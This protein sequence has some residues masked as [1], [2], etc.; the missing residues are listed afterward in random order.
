MFLGGALSGLLA[1]I[2]GVGGAVRSMFLIS[3]GMPK[4]VYIATS[5]LIA[6]VIDCVRIPVYYSSIGLPY[7]PLLFLSLILIA[8]IGV[9]IGKKL[10]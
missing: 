6:L 2:I 7:E 4:E 3:F 1:G 10:F 8:Y 5:A 9:K